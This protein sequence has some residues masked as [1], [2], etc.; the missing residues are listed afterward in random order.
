MAP[1]LKLSLDAVEVRP[2]DVLRGRV[3]LLEPLP[4]AVTLDVALVGAGRRTSNAE[5]TRV[6]LAR[7]AL[8]AGAVHPFELPLSIALLPTYLGQNVSY[9]WEIMATVDVPWAIDPTVRQRITV[10]PRVVDAAGRAALLK[11]VEPQEGKGVV[12]S[13]WVGIALLL[14][15]FGPFL[16]M[17]LPFLLPAALMWWV[18]VSM[19]RTRLRGFTLTAPAVALSGDV[20]PV[21]VGFELRRPIEVDSITVALTCKERWTTGSGKNKQTHVAVVHRQEET[22]VGRCVLAPEHAL[23]PATVRAVAHLTVPAAGPPTVG[24]AVLWEVEARAFL[25]GWP[26]PHE[27]KTPFVFGARGGAEPPRPP[28]AIERASSGVVFVPHGEQPPLGLDIATAGA[29]IW[30]WLGLA[31][32]G[33][34]LLAADL[35]L[36]FAGRIDLATEL[37]APHGPHLGSAVGLLALLVGGAMVVLRMVR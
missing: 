31:L 8:D 14:V 26:D 16:L 19:I 10:L 29:S 25:V 12:I 37:G 6:T 22:L 15:C 9:E 34:A 11:Q 28:E 30:G 17:L 33:G 24:S 13:P 27:L 32:A 2:G 1:P 35:A 18:K 3:E 4:K 21:E 23:S 5:H 36:W 7:G 20:L